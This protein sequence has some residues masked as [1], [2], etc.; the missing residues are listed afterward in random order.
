M[1]PKRCST[2]TS[3][4]RRQHWG[5]TSCQ[6]I[7]LQEWHKRRTSAR[8]SSWATITINSSTGTVAFYH[9]MSVHSFHTPTDH[10]HRGHWPCTLHVAEHLRICS[11]WAEVNFEKK[12]LFD[13]RPDLPHSL[14]YP[15]DW[16]HFHSNLRHQKCTK[17]NP[18]QPIVFLN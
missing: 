3:V 9:P 13:L 16:Y 17:F 1:I 14:I 5:V 7:I 2:G 12:Q 6:S 8:S 15:V 4:V 11:L 18:A 10:R